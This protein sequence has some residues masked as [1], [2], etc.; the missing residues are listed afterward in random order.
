MMNI[1]LARKWRSRNFD[2][3]VGQSLSVRILKNS[4]YLNQFFPVY[5]FSGQRGC[6]KTSTARIFA[7]ALNCFALEEF[8]KNPKDHSLPCLTCNSCQAMS[9]MNHP[10]FIEIDAASHTGVDNVR[11]IIEAASLLPVMGRKKIYLIDEAHMLSKAAFNAFLKILEEPP[12]GVLFIL[13]TTDVQKIIDTVRSRC[14]QIFFKPI[15]DSVLTDHLSTICMDEKIKHEK[16]GLQLIVKHA[17]GSVRDAINMLEQARYSSS[18]VSTASVKQVLGHADDDLLINLLRHMFK[19][20]ASELLHYYSASRLPSFDPA[21]VWKQLVELARTALWIKHGVNRNTF[22]ELSASFDLLL[23]ECTLAQ[24]QSFIDH[25]YTQETIFMRTTAQHA[26]IEMVLLHICYKNRSHNNSGTPP[27]SASPFA[28]GASAD[29]EESGDDEA[30]EDQEEGVNPFND[31]DWQQ[32]ITQLKE[33]HD[34]I[35]LS[36]FTQAKLKEKRSDGYLVLSLSQQLAFFKDI[37]IESRAQWQPLLQRTCLGCVDIIAEFTEHEITQLV[38]AATVTQV[39]GNQPKQA[40]VPRP[41]MIH[42]SNSFTYKQK[43][44][45]TLGSPI[46]VSDTSQWPRTDQ[47]LHHFPGTVTEIK[48]ELLA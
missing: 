39:S 37:L 14:F 48:K 25:L 30:A 4:L 3:L 21:Y 22:V 35:L 7:S 13:A 33:L 24:I 32:F 31:A 40:V 29:E 47:L 28:S 38:R 15:D 17:Q 1:N 11:Q 46:D 10:D 34:P 44:I 8:Q 12:K 41:A 26:F 43:K 36:L 5:L 42:K 6:G 45:M 18:L 2:Q 9:L 20:S 19:G 23:R 27:I 16:S